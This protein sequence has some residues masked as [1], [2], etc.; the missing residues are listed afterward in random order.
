MK[1]NYS[2]LLDEVLVDD[3]ELNEKTPL[4]AWRIKERAMSRIETKRTIRFHWLPKVAVIAAV[5]M[6]LTLTAF[7]AEDIVETVVDSG[8]QIASFFG[9]PMTE[10]RKEIVEDIGKVYE[11]SISL[12]TTT[13][14][15]IQMIA[16]AHNL[17]VHLRIEAQ[18]GKVLRDL[19][20]DDMKF[21]ADISI[22]G[23]GGVGCGGYSLQRVTP[24]PDENPNDNVK[25]FV[26]DIASWG[27][28]TFNDGV[29]RTLTISYLTLHGA[30]CNADCFGEHI[31]APGCL[32]IL[33]NQITLDIELDKN[34][35]RIIRDTGGITFEN[36]EH[37]F[38]VTV[39]SM[40]ITPLSI[41]FDWDYT[42][43]ENRDICPGA[44][45]EFE[46]FFKDGTSIKNKGYI[47]LSDYGYDPENLVG[48]GDSYSFP[49]PVLLENIDYIVFGG[50][51][52][53]DVN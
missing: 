12:N 20:E 53:V 3:I 14:T 31:L 37:G 19:T 11:E 30:N 48:P 39:N 52:I 17:Y 49:Q 7:A 6:A 2:D 22:N 34:D 16:D 32:R 38:S 42:M 46:V 35:A 44:G 29:P 51:Y 9:K 5:I 18:E 28:T 45:G 23:Y 36:E 40:I 26:F 8:K 33:T 24:I 43:P 4:S 25:E 50:E 13:V 10:D 21:Y 1:Q 15:P 27:N 41:R 47:R